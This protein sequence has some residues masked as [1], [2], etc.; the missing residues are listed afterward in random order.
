MSLIRSILAA[1]AGVML[2]AAPLAAQKASPFN[3]TWQLNLAKSKYDPASLTPK[4]A[5]T[6]K[7]TITAT[8]VNTVADGVDSQGRKTHVEYTAKCDGT[9][10]PWHGTI[11]GKPNPDQDGISVKC[12]DANTLHI[13]NSLKGKPTTTFHNVVAADGKTRTVAMTGTNAQGVK[14]NHTVVYDKQ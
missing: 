12:L 8:E 10:A 13:V 6:V 11:D 7:Y 9:V 5:T 3:G 14:V 4:A 2:V 1:A